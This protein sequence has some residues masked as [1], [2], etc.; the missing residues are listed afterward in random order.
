MQHIPPEAKGK[1]VPFSPL[2]EKRAQKKGDM[3]QPT[4]IV[5][6][7]EIALGRGME[8][9][10]DA[11]YLEGVLQ[12]NIAALTVLI[13]SHQKHPA[14]DQDPEFVAQLYRHRA[15][16]EQKLAS[17]QGVRLVGRDMQEVYAAR[18]KN[19]KIYTHEKEKKA[20]EK[21]KKER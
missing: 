16:F 18:A 3:S 17:V 10:R 1:I 20:E 15:R 13:E 7:A 21:E 5:K 2:R 4:P 11:E 8:A 19:I 14:V 6:G 12:E 9:E